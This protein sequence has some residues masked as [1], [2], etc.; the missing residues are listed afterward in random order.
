MPRFWRKASSPGVAFDLSVFAVVVVDVGGGVVVSGVG[1]VAVA[2]VV[3]A[4]VRVQRL[5]TL[6][7]QSV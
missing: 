5:E 4:R 2:V 1:G 7:L 3:V 6:I